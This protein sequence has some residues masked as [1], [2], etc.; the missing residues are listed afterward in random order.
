MK[1]WQNYSL[2]IHLKNIKYTIINKCVVHPVY[3][4]YVYNEKTKAHF[5]EGILQKKSEFGFFS[6]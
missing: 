1:I 6:Q 4:L 5:Q 2:F 3:F